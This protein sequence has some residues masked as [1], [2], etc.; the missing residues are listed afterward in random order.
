MILICIDHLYYN[1]NWDIDSQ[2]REQ[3]SHPRQKQSRVTITRL[4]AWMCLI[5]V[6]LIPKWV[7]DVVER[8]VEE[9]I[10]GLGGEV[11]QLEK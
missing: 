2:L 9:S 5:R 11:V 7:A 4:D 1:T 10:W 3:E 6:T 8:S